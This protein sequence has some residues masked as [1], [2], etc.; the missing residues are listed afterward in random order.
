MNTDD[1]LKTATKEKESG[2]Y[3][4]ACIYLKQAYATMDQSPVWFT[5]ET[6]LR[7]PSYLQMAGKPK[8]AWEAF[9]Q[10]IKNGYPHQPIAPG[11]KAFDLAT[12]FDKMRL[13]LQREM[14]SELTF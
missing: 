14:G 11:L 10:L 13:F 1:L 6:Y 7:L 2:N 3:E 9:E 12:T 5:V 4:Q 8:E